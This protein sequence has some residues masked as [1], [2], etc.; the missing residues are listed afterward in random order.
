[1]V[2]L[3]TVCIGRYLDAAYMVAGDVPL[4]DTTSAVVDFFAEAFAVLTIEIVANVFSWQTPTF[5][6]IR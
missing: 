4:V 3:P 2:L 5:S 1:M 6:I